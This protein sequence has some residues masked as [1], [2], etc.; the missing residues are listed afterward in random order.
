MTTTLVYASYDFVRIE[1]EFGDIVAWDIPIWI[2][3]SMLP[4]GFAAITGRLIW[5]ASSHW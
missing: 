4:I 5:H 1:R 2:V 3:L